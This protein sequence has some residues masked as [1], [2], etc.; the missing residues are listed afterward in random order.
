[1]RIFSNYLIAFKAQYDDYLVHYLVK[2]I[3][4]YMNKAEFQANIIISPYQR[5]I[6]LCY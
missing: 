1:M 6:H 2:D 3:L 4:K 5:L